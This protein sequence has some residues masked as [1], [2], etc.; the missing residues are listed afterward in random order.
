[1]A[2]PARRSS[3]GSRPAPSARPRVTATWWWEV[4][5][6]GVTDQLYE[7][8]RSL[9]PTR[10]VQ[11]FANT[12]AIERIEM[13]LRLDVE[14]PLYYALERLPTLIPPVSVYYQAGHLVALLTVLVWAG[15]GTST[16]TTPRA[17]DES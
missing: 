4:P 5:L 2:R 13:A 16:A 3:G 15:A 8:T 1:M 10:I 6:I 7:L 9:A 12:H 11:A 17:G 14:C